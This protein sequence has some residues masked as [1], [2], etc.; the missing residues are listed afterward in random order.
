MNNFLSFILVFSFIT[1]TVYS[2]KNIFKDIT[3][4]LAKNP[5]WT[6]DIPSEAEFNVM[7]AEEKAIQEAALASLNIEEINTKWNDKLS[8]QSKEFKP[9]A[10][11][12]TTWIEYSSLQSNVV[13]T[14]LVNEELDKILNNN[15]ELKNLT[16]ELEE[17]QKQLKEIQVFQQFDT[18]FQPWLGVVTFFSALKAS[19]EFVPP[20]INLQ[21]RLI[22]VYQSPLKS[23]SDDDD[24]PPLEEVEDAADEASKMEEVD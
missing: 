23:Q 11:L 20:P 10:G 17:K 22:V 24:L 21:C 3:K 6:V 16:V 15:S 1:N 14:N 9:L 2:Q 8:E 5:N 13:E 18:Q 4:A 12:N 19:I 7:I